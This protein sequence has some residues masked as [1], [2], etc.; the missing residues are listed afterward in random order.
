[1]TNPYAPPIDVELPASPRRVLRLLLFCINFG[2]AGGLVLVGGLALFHPKSPIDSMS[3]TMFS[4][5]FLV[6]AMVECIAHIRSNYRLERKL[7]YV[8]LGA[9][10]LVVAQLVAFLWL[11][12]PAVR[13]SEFRDSQVFVMAWCALLAYLAVCG[14]CRIRWTRSPEF[15]S[16]LADRTGIDG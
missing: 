14:W 15:N 5:P 2:S 8:N 12:M 9:A 7:A 11:V 3:A 13:P 1:M 10:G 16:V 4:L 6:Y